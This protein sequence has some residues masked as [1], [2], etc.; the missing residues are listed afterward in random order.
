MLFKSSCIHSLQKG[1]QSQDE[2]KLT[3]S[4]VEVEEEGTA[5]VESSTEKID[6]E[7][8]TSEVE[9]GKNDGEKDIET[10][11]IMRPGVHLPR[12]AAKSESALEDELAAPVSSSVGDRKSV[13]G[14]VGR[15]AENLV[16]ERVADIS[17][18]VFRNLF[19]TPA[20]TGNIPVGGEVKD[21]GLQKAAEAEGGVAGG[22]AS[23]GCAEQEKEEEKGK[24]NSS[25]V[26]KDDS[27]DR[28]QRAEES[29]DVVSSVFEKEEDSTESEQGDESD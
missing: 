27:D 20:G 10:K 19:S 6:D 2:D 5:K 3:E 12:K 24:R 26:V 9:A 14:P 28:S 23:E 29:E 25:S 21:E 7:S 15:D 16:K 17:Y 11:V 13:S 1:A 4:A 18:T 22:E 8:K